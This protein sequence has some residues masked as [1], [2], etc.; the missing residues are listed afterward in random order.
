MK[1]R[2]GTLF[3]LFLYKTAMRHERS[4]HNKNGFL[5]DLRLRFIHKCT[6]TVSQI[7]INKYV[8]IMK[9]TFYRKYHNYTLD[10][11]ERV[12][13]ELHRLMRRKEKVATTRHIYAIN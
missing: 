3:L 7:S 4:K 11:V 13:V 6:E 1:N 8:Y 9:I 12:I 5:L 2:I 10:E